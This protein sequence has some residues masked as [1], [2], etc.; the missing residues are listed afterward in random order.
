MRF[1]DI[2]TIA[3]IIYAVIVTIVD[4]KYRSEL[5]KKKRVNNP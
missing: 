2:V 3:A 1:I 5:K 4:I